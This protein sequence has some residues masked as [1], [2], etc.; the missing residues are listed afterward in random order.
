M[1]WKG[2]RKKDIYES[3][4]KVVKM[5]KIERKR[6]KIKIGGKRGVS[7]KRESNNRK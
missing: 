1:K 3:I 2:Y 6:K 7:M 4:L 5:K